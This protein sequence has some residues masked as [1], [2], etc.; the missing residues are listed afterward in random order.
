MMFE[1]D[2]QALLQAMVIWVGPVLFGFLVVLL[3]ERVWR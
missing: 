2:W 1:E 3:L